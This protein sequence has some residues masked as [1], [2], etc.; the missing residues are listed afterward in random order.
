MQ[1]SINIDDLWTVHFIHI[2][3]SYSSV[4]L[5]ILLTVIYIRRLW[6]NHIFEPNNFWRSFL[7]SFAV[8]HPQYTLVLN[9]EPRSSLCV[10]RAP[11]KRLIDDCFRL[12]T[13]FACLQITLVLMGF[14]QERMM[15][16]GYVSS[17]DHTVVH[18]FNNAQFLVFVNRIFALIL[19]GLYLLFNWKNEPPHIPPLYKHSYTSI[20]NTLSSWCQYEALKYVSF[21]TQTVFKASKILP[22]MLMGFIIR[23]ERYGKVDCGIAIALAS[24]ASLFFLS[25]SLKTSSIDQDGFLFW[26]NTLLIIEG[27]IGL[28]S[29]RVTTV[30]GL[31][32]MISYLAFDAFTLNWQKSLF[33]TK[34]R[35]SKYQMMFGVN[36]FSMLLCLAVL[37]HEDTLISS[38]NF[39]LNHKDVVN[40]LIILSL[41]GALGQVV[42][43]MT[44]ERYGPIVFAVMMTLRQIFSITLSTIVYGHPVSFC[45]LIG[46][47]VTFASIF[48]SIFRQYYKIYA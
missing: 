15:T 42:I 24:G 48:C 18:R 17:L 20:S 16:Q 9:I 30:Q 36:A 40:D 41:S 34:P 4:I 25:N 21:P 33:D 11:S 13:Y 22:T 26:F 12:L 43:Y 27:F 44:I 10:G 38:F 31:C 28:N 14:I 23:G 8:G 37:I 35:L 47:T 7:I 19:S 5:P 2:L 39:F 6:S 3:I 45:S 1:N 46:L 29:D 32:L